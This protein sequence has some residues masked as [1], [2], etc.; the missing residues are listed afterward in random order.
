MRTLSSDVLTAI[1]AQTTDKAFLNLLT[2]DHDDLPS[3]LRLVDNTENVTSRGNVYTA[4]PFRAALPP[5]TENE[6]PRVQIMICNVDRSLMDEIRA[7][8]SPPSITLE[9]I[10]ASTPDTVE[11]GPFSF[12][13]KSV[14]YDQVTIESTI[15]FEEDFLTEP[16]PAGR[17]SPT[18]FPGLFASVT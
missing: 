15:G 18:D 14:D 4:F 2:I 8:V 6:V 11:V 17:F 12:V 10:L 16:F 1:H 9:V 13:M 7:L 3:P 5:E